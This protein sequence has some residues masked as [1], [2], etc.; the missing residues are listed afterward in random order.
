MGNEELWFMPAGELAVAIRTKRLSPIE[1]TE[2]V[3]ARIEKVNPTLNAFCTVTA[4]VARA[5]AKAAEAAVMRGDT[6]GPIHGVPF[7][8]K[9]LVITKGIRTTW[10][11]KIYADHVPAED[12]PLVERLLAAGGIMLGKTATPEFGWKPATDSP[13]F[14]VTRNPWNLERTPGGSSGGA[15]A[16]LAA[17][18]G[19]LGVGTDGGGSIRIPS[20]FCGL[21]GL[22]PSYGRVP[23]YPASAGGTL[24]HPGPMTRTVRDAALM[25]NVMKGPDERDRLSLPADGTDYLTALEGGIRGLRVGWSPDLGY[26]VVHP[27]VRAATE[28]AVKTFVELGCHVEEAHPWPKDRDPDPIYGTL[29]H[30]THGG[31]LGSY[32][33][34]WRDK[35]DPN[36]VPVIEE[37]MGMPAPRL[38]E[39]HMQREAFWQVV[40]QFFARYDL[41]VTPTLALPPFGFGIVRPREIAGRPVGVRGA[42]PFTYPFNLTGQPAAT[43]PCGWSS[44][45]TPIGLQIVGRRFDDATVLRAS[46]AF[47][48]ARPWAS[49]RPTL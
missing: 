45:G 33:P 44:E 28:A 48:A 16:A 32:L 26:A 35:L 30:A 6:L 20:S 42:Y 40:R 25:L 38:V 36:L 41:L 22:K 43:V 24:S 39:A 11:S 34:E 12:A 5:Q 10:G 17:G 13:L 19:P 29:S 8:V 14:G 46:A 4:D 31:R 37:G 23:T 9:D 15:G 1:V 47:E 7:S 27:E 18:L 2:A 49:R 21:Y 3:L